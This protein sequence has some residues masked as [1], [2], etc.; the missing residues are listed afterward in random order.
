MKKAALRKECGIKRK[1]PANS[2][3]VSEAVSKC[4]NGGVPN[5]ELIPKIADFFGISI[6]SLFVEMVVTPN[7][8]AFYYANILKPYLSYAATQKRPPPKTEVF[9]S[10]V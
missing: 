3:G 5:T 1:E 10:I 6:N 8:Y 4:E 7:C 2:V 9:R